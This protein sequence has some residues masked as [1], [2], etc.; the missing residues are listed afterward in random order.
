MIFQQTFQ[1]ILGNSRDENCQCQDWTRKGRGFFISQA[2]NLPNFPVDKSAHLSA[3]SWHVCAPIQSPLH[4]ATKTDLLDAVIPGKT[5]LKHNVVLCQSANFCNP[6]PLYVILCAL[7]ST[8]VLLPLSLFW[9]VFLTPSPL[10]HLANFEDMVQ[11]SSPPGN[12][13]WD[14]P[15]KTKTF[16]WHLIILTEASWDHWFA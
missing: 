16:L 10:P 7:I 13:S 6:P 15:G 9:P 2:R 3:S 4:R 5:F 14:P 1:I 11:V 12:L 8:L